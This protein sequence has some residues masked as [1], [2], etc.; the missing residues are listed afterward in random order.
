MATIEGNPELNFVGDGNFINKEGVRSFAS[1]ELQTSAR[2]VN[3]QRGNFLGNTTHS[4]LVN[5]LGTNLEERDRLTRSVNKIQEIG[6]SAL[7]WDRNNYQDEE[8]FERSI[9]AKAEEYSHGQ[10]DAAHYYSSLHNRHDQALAVTEFYRNFADRVAQLNQEKPEEIDQAEWNN[11][12]IQTINQLGEMD[13]EKEIYE[14]AE[15]IHRARIERNA[16][17][18]TPVQSEPETVQELVT[19]EE[20]RSEVPASAE[21]EHQDQIDE[22]VS[23][24]EEQ[25]PEPQVEAVDEF[26]VNQQEIDEAY[27]GVLR[28]KEVYARFKR[29]ERSAWKSTGH[30]I[31]AVVKNIG[32]G[33]K[34]GFKAGWRGARRLF[35]R[36]QA[37]TQPQPTQ[38]ERAAELKRKFV[39]NAREEAWSNY[40]AALNR[41]TSLKNRRSHGENKEAFARGVAEDLGEEMN[42]LSQR[43]IELNN[44]GL[45]HKLAA[46]WVARPWWQRFIGGWVVNAGIGAAIGTG[47]FPAAAILLGLR[48][49]MGTAGTE[50]GLAKLQTWLSM[51]FGLKS[52]PKRGVE[53]AVGRINKGEAARRAAAWYEYRVRNR[54]ENQTELEQ[55]IRRTYRDRM[56]EDLAGCLQDVST[57]QAAGLLGRLT[58][59]VAN[60]RN[61]E[62]LRSERLT[63]VGRTVL[64]AL[65]SAWATLHFSPDQ[66]FG[67]PNVGTAKLGVGTPWGWLE[68]HQPHLGIDKLNPNFHWPWEN[69]PDVQKTMTYRFEDHDPFYGRPEAE[70][71]LNNP[72]VHSL[73][74][75]AQRLDAESRYNFDHKLDH[76]D[77]FKNMEQLNLYNERVADDHTAGLALRKTMDVVRNLNRSDIIDRTGKLEDMLLKDG[78][79]KAPTPEVLVPYLS[80]NK[81]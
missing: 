42:K 79:I 81:F 44:Q 54:I 36:G 26:L 52:E 57:A 27:A 4:R 60:E 30:N 19:P 3:E 72:R 33:F 78:D 14:N 25:Q 46:G 37:E 53:S 8:A 61:D 22:E 47:L 39:V 6:N 68:D 49:L 11:Q 20:N 15:V 17:Q 75:F 21:A 65:P 55:T 71:G 34:V 29:T 64:A 43:E 51:K 80:T 31:R 66:F 18:I 9:N 63:T 56:A 77:P 1:N 76:F 12:M 16:Q 59:D 50:A 24:P 7:V 2:R 38:A 48:V 73:K 23:V 45:Y 13:V 10:H 58:I 35:R 67:K 28:S 74:G 41:W 32:H 70:G 62:A 69:Y 40:Q 5:S